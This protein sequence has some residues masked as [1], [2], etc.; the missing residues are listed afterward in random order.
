MG[1]E[2]EGLRRRLEAGGYRLTRPRRRVLEFVARRRS[3]T[4]NEALTQLTPGLGRA[5]IF[6]TLRLFSKLG[7][8]EQVRTALGRPIYIL[9]L[10]DHHHQLICIACGRVAEV[11]GCEILAAVS[12][13]AAR[14]GFAATGHR[15]EILG[16]CAACQSCE[17]R[18]VPDCASW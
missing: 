9:C 11:A 3:F 5:T 15:L 7:I 17:G 4:P 8:I 16:L 10:P 14:A 6:R 2:L 13:Q 18:E 12:A 1:P